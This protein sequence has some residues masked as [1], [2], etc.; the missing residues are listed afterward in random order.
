MLQRRLGILPLSILDTYSNQAIVTRTVA[1]FRKV[2]T[3]PRDICGD[4]WPM[5]LGRREFWRRGRRIPFTLQPRYEVRARQLAEAYA[6]QQEAWAAI[7]EHF[8][9]GAALPRTD[10]L[11]PHPATDVLAR[12]IATWCSPQNL[13]YERHS[14]TE[15]QPVVGG[16]QARAPW[17]IFSTI[18][19]NAYVMRL[20]R[21]VWSISPG[22]RSELP[23]DFRSVRTET[24]V[25]H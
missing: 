2:W 5:I 14:R 17:L 9:L 4:P 1:G 12:I 22:L 16:C 20:S 23:R 8:Q 10:P 24:Q 3:P 15:H 25:I 18:V 7:L 19:E 11:P 21:G 13:S 6:L